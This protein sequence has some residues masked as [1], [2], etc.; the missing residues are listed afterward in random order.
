MHLKLGNN[1]AVVPASEFL[2]DIAEGIDNLGIHVCG[3][4]PSYALARLYYFSTWHSP[5]HSAQ[6]KTNKYTCKCVTIR[7]DV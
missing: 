1:M 6:T 7:Q 5:M 4:S 3:H 2:Q